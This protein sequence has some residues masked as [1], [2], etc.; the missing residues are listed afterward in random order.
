M[1][2]LCLCAIVTS[3]PSRRI[4]IACACGCCR[5][6]SCCRVGARC[7]GGW[8]HARSTHN[9]HVRWV[10][11][12]KGQMARQ[13]GGGRIIIRYIYIGWPKKSSRM[14]SSFQNINRI[15]IDCHM[16]VVPN[17]EKP[18]PEIVWAPKSCWR[19]RR[20]RKSRSKRV[21]W[22]LSLHSLY[23]WLSLVL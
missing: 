6:C 10:E 20:S 11:L 9:P 4:G 2:N 16:M 1:T 22:A 17:S 13:V 14:Y 15:G 19:S 12:W 7:G 8:V 23:K 21:A 5:F 18:D 3:L